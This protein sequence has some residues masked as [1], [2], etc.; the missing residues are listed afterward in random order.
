MR[1]IKM[2]YLLIIFLFFGCISSNTP[3]ADIQ[4]VFDSVNNAM[5]YDNTAPKWKIPPIQKDF[6]GKEYRRGSCS[7]YVLLYMAEL[8][9]HGYAPEQLKIK[10]NHT[11]L[12]VIDHNGNVW[13][14]DS[15]KQIIIKKE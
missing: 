15:A 8:K 14:L 7:N 1:Y 11:F 5:V 10:F 3:P 13:W 9:D 12:E 4:R 2:K 6:L